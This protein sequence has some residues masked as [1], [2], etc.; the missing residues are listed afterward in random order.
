MHVQASAVGRCIVSAPKRREDFIS[1]NRKNACNTVD[2]RI[3][4]ESRR[5][6]TDNY[7][8]HRDDPASAPK[9]GKIS[10]I[11]AGKMAEAMIAGMLSQGIRQFSAP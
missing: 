11:G 8:S 6:F 5:M 2:P 1:R 4:W 7:G 10:F 9:I 3:L